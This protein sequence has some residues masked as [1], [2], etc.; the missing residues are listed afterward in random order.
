MKQMLEQVT[1]RY[2]NRNLMLSTEMDRMK[3]ETKEERKGQR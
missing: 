2:F 1:Y 3:G